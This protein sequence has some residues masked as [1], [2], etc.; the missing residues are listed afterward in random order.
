[1]LNYEFLKKK[2]KLVFAAPSKRKGKKYDVYE[3]NGKYITSFG[4]SNYQQY[5][6]KLGFYSNLDH[7]DKKRR[8][9]FKKRFNKLISLCNKKSAMY[10]SD[11]YLW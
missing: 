9:K 11:K 3:Y 8:Y 10:Y 4:A 6:D 2:D 5:K 7:L 1:M